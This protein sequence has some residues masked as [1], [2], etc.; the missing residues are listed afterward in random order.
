MHPMPMRSLGADL[1]DRILIAS[2]RRRDRL[3]EW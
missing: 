2:G 1:L 3:R